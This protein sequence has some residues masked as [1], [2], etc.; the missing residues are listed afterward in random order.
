M[1][2]SKILQNILAARVQLL[3]SNT[4]ILDD[5]ILAINTHQRK[6]TK[7]KKSKRRQKRKKLRKLSERKKK[8]LNL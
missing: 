8:K 2:S 5:N 3:H 6:R 4:N 7:L 1:T